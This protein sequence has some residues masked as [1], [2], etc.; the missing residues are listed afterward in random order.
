MMRSAIMLAGLLAAQACA[1]QELAPEKIGKT[2]L[3]DFE[4][5]YVADVVLPHMVDG[6]VYVLDV[7]LNL[8]GMMESGF[9]GMMLAAPQRGQVYVPTSFY[10][11]LTR[12]ARTDVVQVFDAHTLTVTD[13]IPIAAARAQALTYRNLFQASSD[14]TTLFIQDAT[15]ATSIDVL[16]VASRRRFEVQNPGC[17]G[18]YPSLTN[19]LRFSTLCGGGTVGSYTINEA[20]DGAARKTSAKLFDATNDPWFTHAEHDV[21]SYLF[22]SYKGTIARVSLED[23][24]AKLLDSADVAAGAPGWAPGGFQPFA[25]DPKSGVA[26]VLMHGD[27]AEGSHKNPSAEI[28]SY[29]VK[30]KKLLARSPAAGLTSITISPSDPSALFAINPVESKIQRFAVDPQTRRVAKTKEIKLG[31]SAALIEVSK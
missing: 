2:V 9:A 27:A 6:R 31:E 11:R 1:A 30:G 14:G 18:I 24:T 8:K 17:Y 15:P 7:D 21:D 10:E 25:Y 23:E 16:D 5:V 3:G 22:V 20:H 26:Y 4:R 13:E 12:G 19:P 29:D 28:W